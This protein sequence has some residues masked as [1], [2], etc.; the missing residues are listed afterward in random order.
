MDKLL[1][2]K[3]N[4]TLASSYDST[5]MKMQEILTNKWY[6]LSK[7]FYGNIEA[8]G[9]FSFKQKFVFLSTIPFGQMVYLNGKLT[10]DDRGTLINISLSPNLF[11]VFLIYLFPLLLLNIFFGDNS[12]LGSSHTRLNNAWVV[13]L[14]ELILF[15]M[16]QIPSYL[17]RRKFEKAIIPRNHIQ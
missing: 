2:K 5:K 6:D 10:Q 1:R 7:P 14:M 16:I 17:L 3:Y 4:Y 13:L 15:I 12:L 8:D 9:T 11:L